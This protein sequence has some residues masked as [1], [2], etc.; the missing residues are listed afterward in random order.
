MEI[1]D[2]YYKYGYGEMY[3]LANDKENKL[4]RF[5]QFDENDPEKIRYCNDPTKVI[6]V[7]TASKSYISDNPTEDPDKYIHNECG[8]LVVKKEIIAVGQEVNI[9]DDNNF[10][11]ITTKKAETYKPIVSADFNDT[12]Q[13]VKHTF[14][15]NW[16]NINILGK[17]IVE[18]DGTCKPGEYCTLYQ[19]KDKNLFG[20]AVPATNKDNIKF[21]VLNR[22]SPKTCLIFFK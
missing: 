5:M 2:L 10:Q 1:E 13:Y 9:S 16:R 14:R 19:G 6:G 3:E 7:S 22:I 17:C 12:K 18:D 20:I 15:P 8:D 4:C 11:I 21:Y